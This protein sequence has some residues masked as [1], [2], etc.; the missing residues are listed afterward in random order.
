MHL[1]APTANTLEP[2]QRHVNR[3]AA[4]H[5]RSLHPRHLSHLSPYTE[6]RESSLHGMLE[7]ISCTQQPIPCHTVRVANVDVQLHAPGDGVVYVG[8]LLPE[9]DGCD[10]VRGSC[11]TG[12]KSLVQ[13]THMPRER[14]RK[15]E[16]LKPPRMRYLRECT[17]PLGVSQ[18]S[19]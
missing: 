16:A 1:S 7:R 8:L 17:S 5:I 12:L 13:S 4:P 11:M 14:R 18:V 3:C 10:C 6:V 15:P 2:H 9:T 19:I